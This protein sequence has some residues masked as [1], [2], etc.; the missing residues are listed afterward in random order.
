M[1]I[2][3]H[4][5]DTLAMA[6]AAGDLP[7]AFNLVI[8]TH[9]SMSDESRARVAT[10]EALGGAVIETG[11]AAA[12][13]EGSLDACMARIAGLPPVP[14]AAAPRRSGDMPAPL[15]D[16][17]GT[18]LA[19]VNWRPVG[20]GVRQSILR[21]GPGATARLLMIPAG[22]AMPDHGHNGLELTLVLKGA[23]LDGADR[24]GPGDIEVADP[25]M[26]HTPVAEAWSDCVCLVASDAPLRFQSLIP[27]LAQPFLRI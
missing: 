3:H 19:G 7:E 2:R 11:E 26:Q 25:G 13:D 8:A 1:T 21:T 14:R 10:F 16:Y 12:L 17:V 18:D 24:F 15:A 22:Q 9:L 20:L 27:R 4:I 23:F 5:P 6:Y